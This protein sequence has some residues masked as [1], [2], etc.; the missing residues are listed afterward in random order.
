MKINYNQ[1]TTYKLMIASLFIFIVPMLSSIQ[2]FLIKNN[3]IYLD[4]FLDL[5]ISIIGYLQPFILLVLVINALNPKVKHVE[6]SVIFLAV[7]LNYFSIYDNIIVNLFGQIDG[8]KYYYITNLLEGYWLIFVVAMIS[9]GFKK[10]YSFKQDNIS[11]TNVIIRV[12]LIIIWSIIIVWSI[13]EIINI[14]IYIA[15]NFNIT[16]YVPDSLKILSIAFLDKMLVLFENMKDGTNVIIDA[17]SVNLI[18]PCNDINDISACEGHLYHFLTLEYIINLIIIPITSYMMYKRMTHENKHYMIGLLIVANILAIFFDLNEMFFIMV[19]LMSPLLLVIMSLLN[20]LTI[21]CLNTFVSDNIY[22]GITDASINSFID[23]FS[24][25]SSSQT[26][27]VGTLLTLVYVLIIILLIRNNR[28]FSYGTTTPIVTLD[29]QS[30]M[31]SP[32]E[33]YTQLNEDV[34][35]LMNKI[36]LEN[37][38]IINFN[39]DEISIISTEKISLELPEKLNFL[40]IEVHSNQITVT[41]INDAKVEYPE[42]KHA[43][44]QMVL[45]HYNYQQNIKTE[46]LIEVIN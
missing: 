33:Y 38:N 20:G 40:S 15:D 12:L 13:N 23:N 32:S 35:I 9:L 42:L 26:F 25:F 5:S 43:Y 16:G 28:I 45:K 30:I 37:I 31:L 10:N 7:V 39:I 36:K 29:T 18:E 6:Y 17:I 19:L 8:S 4:Y 21:L 2:G 46:N 14:I 11:Y 27:I 1:K 24:L 34:N 22:T 41:H 3:I 44:K